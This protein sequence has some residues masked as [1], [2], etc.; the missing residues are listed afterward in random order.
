MVALAAWPCHLAAVTA[1]SAASCKQGQQRPFLAERWQGQQAR[2]QPPHTS[3]ARQ[4]R[5]SSRRQSSCA[6]RQ[7]GGLQQAVLLLHT[8][9]PWLLNRMLNRVCGWCSYTNVLAHGSAVTQSSLLLHQASAAAQTHPLDLPVGTVRAA[10]RP[11][12]DCS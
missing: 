12:A 3:K 9:L 7:V 10:Q 1:A 6:R 5:C 2:I 8:C 11:K 4:G